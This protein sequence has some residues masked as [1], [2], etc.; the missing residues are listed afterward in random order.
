M[1]TVNL[2]EMVL[3]NAFKLSVIL[4][5]PK[6]SDRCIEIEVASIFALSVFQYLS[7]LH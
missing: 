5:Y 6:I 1:S 2:F 7:R 3:S 4:N